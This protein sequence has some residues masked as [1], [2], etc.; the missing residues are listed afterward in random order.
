VAQLQTS[1]FLQEPTADLFDRI[2]TGPNLLRNG[3][4]NAIVS[5]EECQN[6]AQEI[7]SGREIEVASL[8]VAA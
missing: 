4:Q 3:T 1:E 5:L 6:A 8:E 7:V 2:E